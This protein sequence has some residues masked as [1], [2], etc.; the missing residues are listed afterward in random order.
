[1]VTYGV[2]YWGWQEGYRFKLPLIEQHPSDIPEAFFQYESMPTGAEQRALAMRNAWIGRH[3]G[4][5]SETFS[6]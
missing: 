4:D 1:M 5:V 6:K 3:F 2:R